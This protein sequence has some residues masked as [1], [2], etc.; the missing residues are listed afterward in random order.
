MTYDFSVFLLWNWAIQHPHGND[1][2]LNHYQFIIVL[3]R[4]NLPQRIK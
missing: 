1:F 3:L 4:Q 2:M